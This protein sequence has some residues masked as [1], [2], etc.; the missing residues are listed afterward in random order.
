MESKFDARG[1]ISLKHDYCTGQVIMA[2]LPRLQFSEI[3]K[4]SAR[5]SLSLAPM[6]KAMQHFVHKKEKKKIISKKKEIK[7]KQ[8]H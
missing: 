3:L 2:N 5:C 4:Y 8:R 6:K 1:Q 7:K